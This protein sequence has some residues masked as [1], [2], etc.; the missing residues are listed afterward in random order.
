MSES[1]TK[2]DSGAEDSSAPET[3]AVATDADGNPLRSEFGWSDEGA[4]RL[5]RVPAGYMR[6][7]TQELIEGLARERKSEA[8]DL[9]LVE[10]GIASALE[11][12]EQAIQA[13]RKS[14]DS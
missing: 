12:M 9:G 6:D 3:P 5:F 1:D 10:D 2:S 8:I 11:A 4:Q 13:K 7:K 14:G